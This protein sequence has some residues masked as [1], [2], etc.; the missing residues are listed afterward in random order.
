MGMGMTSSP[1]ESL[2]RK[3]S[4]G[5]FERIRQ[6]L[7]KGEDD[8]RFLDARDFDRLPWTNAKAALGRIERR[9]MVAES[10]RD[11]L[12]GALNG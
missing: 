6:A 7:A 4:I 5:D 8:A 1:R 3:R 10:E 9:L 12:R 2:R 11:A